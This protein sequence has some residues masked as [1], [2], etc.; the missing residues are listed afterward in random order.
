MTEKSVTAKVY[1]SR[2]KTKVTVNVYKENNGNYEK[3]GSKELDKEYKAGEEIDVTEYTKTTG[4]TI[5]GIDD[6]VYEFNSE[7][8]TKVGVTKN[9]DNKYIFAVKNKDSKEVNMYFSKRLIEV[10]AQ[11]YTED[12]NAEE[13]QAD[14]HSEK[15]EKSIE[16]PING[17]FK[18]GTA[19][20][21]TPYTKKSGNPV[22]GVNFIGFKFDKTKTLEDGDINEEGG[23]F[24]YRAKGKT[25]K[26]LKF[27]FSRLRGTVTPINAKASEGT[28]TLPATFS[29]IFGQKLD[30]NLK[31]STFTLN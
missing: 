12:L 20:D 31:S 7:E 10:N 9:V 25:T 13:T 26:V 28:A 3:A 29:T 22:T 23:E 18:A 24:K 14:G 8:T 27:Y 21:L 2:Q 4:N 15:S 19:I 16:G 5:T 6:E 11:I 17:K 1:F 30:A